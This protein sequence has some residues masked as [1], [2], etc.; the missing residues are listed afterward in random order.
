M[1][2]QFGRSDETAEAT[3]LGSGRVKCAIALE[4]FSEALGEILGAMVPVSWRPSTTVAAYNDLSEVIRMVEDRLPVLL[5]IH[6]N[7]LFFGP[8]DWIA[9]CSAANPNMRFLFVTGWVQEQ[10]D[11]LLKM[12]EPFH[13]PMTA[14]GLPFEREQFAAALE[15]AL[16]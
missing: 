13:M 12:N 8:E 11:Y 2:E 9:S 3:T 15:A 14:L 4:S 16:R 10:I 1:N 7:L 5:V 6:T